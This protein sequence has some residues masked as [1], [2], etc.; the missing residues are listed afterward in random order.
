MAVPDNI[1]NSILYHFNVFGHV[2]SWCW[3]QLSYGCDQR[4]SDPFTVGHKQWEQAPLQ[5]LTLQ[6]FP[7]V[8]TPLSAII[9]NFLLCVHPDCIW[10]L[11][12]WFLLLLFTVS[13]AC[14]VLMHFHVISPHNEKHRC[15]IR[16][17]QTCLSVCLCHLMDISETSPLVEMCKFK[18]HTCLIWSSF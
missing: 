1:S 10:C 3:S 9:C 7:A 6:W 14:F 2:I 5:H 4:L 16:R 18:R 8:E 17:Q 15:R 11:L 13:N 12:L